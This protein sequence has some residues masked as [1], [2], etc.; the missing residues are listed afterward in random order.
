MYSGEIIS[1]N[2]MEPAS[3]RCEYIQNNI[4]SYNLIKFKTNF[5]LRRRR[6]YYSSMFN[7]SEANN[8]NTQVIVWQK[9][10]K[11]IT[12]YSNNIF[13]ILACETNLKIV[14]SEKIKFISILQRRYYLEIVVHKVLL[15]L[16][17][18]LELYFL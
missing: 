15:R 17:H 1:R 13:I 11:L 14:L 16:L 5:L 7:K 4:I 10:K 18:F 3:Q 8:I 9:L 6:G 2:Y 12:K